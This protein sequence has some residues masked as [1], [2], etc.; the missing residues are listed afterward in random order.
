MCARVV[1]RSESVNVDRSSGDPSRFSTSTHSPS[2]CAGWNWIS[3]MRSGPGPTRASTE[4]D[5]VRGALVAG[6]TAS[7]ALNVLP[8]GGADVDVDADGSAVPASRARSMVPPPAIDSAAADSI[9]HLDRDAAQEATG[10]RVHDDA[11]EARAR[12]RIGLLW[13]Q[14]Q[15]PRRP[16]RVARRLVRRPG[17]G[18]AKRKSSALPPRSAS[19]GTRDR[20]AGRGVARRRA[21]RILRELVLAPADDLDDAVG[22]LEAHRV[23]T[24]LEVEYREPRRVRASC[25]RRRSR[26]ALCA[27]TT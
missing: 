5:V 23:R 24:V 25:A 11:G 26:T 14:H 21:A 20:V 16:A 27:G 22:P 19:S 13:N 2:S 10:R 9:D 17:D 3:A 7:R 15:T 8:A 18:G 1:P 12:E 6:A 4:V